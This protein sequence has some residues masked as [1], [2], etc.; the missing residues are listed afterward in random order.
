MSNSAQQ[1]KTEMEAAWSII[2][3]NFDPEFLFG[4]EGYQFVL[5]HAIRSSTHPLVTG[6]TLLVG[7]APLTNGGNIQIFPGAAT[8]LNVLAVLVNYPQ[9]QK[10]QMT[11][12]TK[13]IGD[14]LDVHILDLLKKKTE[15]TLES[16]NRPVQEPHVPARPR[17]LPRVA[18]AVLASFTPAKFFEKC[19][20]D[21][22]QL[23]NADD[24]GLPS[25]A[26]AFTWEDSP[27][28]MG[29]MHLSQLLAF[30]AMTTIGP[31]LLRWW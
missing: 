15:E 11:K 29:C 25:C 13:D 21:V 14:C 22:Q 30:S 20:G 4:Q 9:S 19:S 2:D 3:A 16:Q 8:Q 17:V 6:V 12:I 10:S 31:L 23:D 5:S 26:E 28:R 7:M 24:I 18:S 1:D 27:T